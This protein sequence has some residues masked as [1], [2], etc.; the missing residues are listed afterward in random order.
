LGLAYAVNF[1][2]KIFP[3]IPKQVALDLIDLLFTY[4]FYELFLHWSKNIRD[5]FFYL[6][7]Y[8]IMPFYEKLDRKS[9]EFDQFNDKLF[10]VNKRLA[11]IG[12]LGQKYQKQII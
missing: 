1:W 10:L 6:I 7:S 2:Y 9:K 5:A 4:N 11:I 8:R 3:I 12:I